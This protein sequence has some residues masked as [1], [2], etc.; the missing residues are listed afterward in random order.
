MSVGNV[1]LLGGILLAGSQQKRYRCEFLER[2]TFQGYPWLSV[3]GKEAAKQVPGW[4]KAFHG[5]L[6]LKNSSE[7]DS[8]P[9]SNHHL[10]KTAAKQF[11]EVPELI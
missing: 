9:F 11:Y 6:S 10:R 5:S 3:L 8:K 2:Q 1:W 4:L 7:A